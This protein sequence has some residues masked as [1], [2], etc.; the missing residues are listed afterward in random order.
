MIGWTANVLL[1]VCSAFV[2]R[3]RWALLFGIAGGILWAFKAA[4]LGMFDLFC[5]EVVIVVLQIRGYL[6][7][8]R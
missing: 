7:W 3:Y 1:I 5:I 4:G 6:K 2:H 8:N